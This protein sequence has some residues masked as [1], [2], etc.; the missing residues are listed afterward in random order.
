MLPK[1]LLRWYGL[2][3]NYCYYITFSIPCRF[4]YKSNRLI[5]SKSKFRW[6]LVISNIA[7]LFVTVLITIERFIWFLTKKYDDKIMLVI[8][9]VMIIGYS[10]PAIISIM[11]IVQIEDLIT[12]ANQG[13]KYCKCIESKFLILYSCCTL[14]EINY[15]INPT[16]KYVRNKNDIE[17]H[18]W[19]K[20]TAKAL[21]IAT[22][23]KVIQPYV[24]QIAAYRILLKPSRH[25]YI[26]SLVPWFHPSPELVIIFCTPMFFITSIAIS[27]LNCWFAILAMHY[28]S[29]NMIF[30]EIK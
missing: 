27:I 28:H 10:I 16:E 4:D 22:F 19:T 13:I 1:N 25:I 20:N 24:T 26:T 14:F 21:K 12:I 2:A 17:T 6:M 9:P 18:Q 5:L 30:H 15:F 11:C 23:V 8:C 7:A 3:I 29:M